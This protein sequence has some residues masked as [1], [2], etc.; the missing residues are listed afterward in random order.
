MTCGFVMS[1]TV[2]VWVTAVWRPSESVA[3]TVTECVPAWKV[4][5]CEPMGW[6]ASHETI[7]LTGEAHAYPNVAT[8]PCG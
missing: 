8:A 4:S 3:V 1:I 2:Y 7:A 6:L 5:S